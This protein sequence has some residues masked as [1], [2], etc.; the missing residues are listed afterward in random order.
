VRRLL[1]LS[2]LLVVIG[3]ASQEPVRQ[4]KPAVPE[5]TYSG[6]NGDSF[7][8][9][10]IINGVDKQSESVAAEYRYLSRLHGEKDKAWRV[11]GQS[12]TSE[13]KNVYDV[14]EIVLIP[15]S[16]KR[17]YYFDVTRFAWK[18]KQTE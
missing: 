9:A 10:I 8:S 14:I 16:E 17:I 11:E 13:E 5:I 7:E 2:V 1:L 3:C 4:K 6:G 15:T 12:M 18:R